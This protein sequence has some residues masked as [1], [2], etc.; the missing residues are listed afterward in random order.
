MDAVVSKSSG[1]HGRGPVIGNLALNE[2]DPRGPRPRPRPCVSFQQ[3]I[4]APSPSSFK[5]DRPLPSHLSPPFLPFFFDHQP[6]FFPFACLLKLLVPSLLP[7]P[8]AVRPRYV[9]LSQVPD[10]GSPSAPK[11]PWHV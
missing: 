11:Q 9:R 4:F 10:I 8:C 3:F 2:L 7:F 6:L 5:G 1:D